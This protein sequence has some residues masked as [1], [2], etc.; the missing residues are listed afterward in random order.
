MEIKVPW[1]LGLIATRSLDRPMPGIDDLVAR[2]QTRIKNGIV[3]YDG[4]ERL[5]ANRKDEKARAD[6]TLN[7][8]DP[9]YALLLKRYVADPRKA[10]EA[11]IA[12]AAADTVPGVV[13]LFWTFRLMVALGFY[14]IFLFAAAFYYT[15]KLD[16]SRK[17]LLRLFLWSLPLPWLAAELGW[18]V[19][20]YGRQPWAIDGVLPTFLASSSV[21][22]AQILFTLCGFVLF[23]S[24]LAVVDLI[25]MRKYVRMGPVEALGQDSSSALRPANAS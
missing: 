13:P 6:L 24:S 3:A 16:F 10:D 1:A 12:K 9:G 20:E 14:F 2:A 4:L 17:W 15:S 8:R 21:S 18:F 7:A 5:K 22:L 23:Y 11:T 19:A 25:L